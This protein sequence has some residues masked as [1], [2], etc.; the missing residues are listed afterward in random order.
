MYLTQKKE[1]KNRSSKALTM[2]I[3]KLKQAFYLF[4]FLVFRVK[5]RFSNIN[6]SF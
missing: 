2:M 6:L 1:R 3:F 4:V 5:E